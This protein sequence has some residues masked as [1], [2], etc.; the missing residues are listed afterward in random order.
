MVLKKERK[1]VGFL[2]TSY[3][4]SGMDFRCIPKKQ[5]GFPIIHYF[6][7]KLYMFSMDIKGEPHMRNKRNE[8]GVHLHN[9][10]Q[11]LF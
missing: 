5:S 4:K 3:Q 1:G 9:L 8:F 2:Q 10:Y 6:N 11:A 7:T